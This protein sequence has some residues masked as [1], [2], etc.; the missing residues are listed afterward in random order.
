MWRTRPAPWTSFDK[1]SPKP[2]QA[3]PKRS[4]LFKLRQIRRRANVVCFRITFTKANSAPISA[5]SHWL[6]SLILPWITARDSS[7]VDESLRRRQCAD[8]PSPHRGRRDGLP[9]SLP[10]RHQ[11]SP[12]CPS[13]RSFRL[14]PAPFL[15][16]ARLR[17]AVQIP[18]TRSK[19]NTTG[20]EI[21][22]Q[23]PFTR[24]PPVHG[25]PCKDGTFPSAADLKAESCRRSGKASNVINHGP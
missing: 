20:R 17:S 11:R 23:L 24:P 25:S 18:P 2:P 13:A 1:R 15:I 7:G 19:S 3:P 9:M 10:R 5:V 22:Q 6:Q 16:T 12:P 21:V 4:C 8:Q 14:G